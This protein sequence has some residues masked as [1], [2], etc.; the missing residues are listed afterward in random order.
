MTA[1]VFEVAK[2]E[3][4]K[5][6]VD[7]IDFLPIMS[8]ELATALQDIDYYHS[9]I[10]IE[11]LPFESTP[12]R[13]FV[14]QPKSLNDAQ[15][16]QGLPPGFDNVPDNI[17]DAVFAGEVLEHF[18][19][20]PVDLLRRL[21]RAIKPTGSI[22][23]TTPSGTSPAWLNSNTNYRGL[24]QYATFR[25][26]PQPGTEAEVKD[27]HIHLYTA[28]EIHELAA[29]A[30]LH[31]RQMLVGKQLVFELVICQPARSWQSV[32]TA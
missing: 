23:I 12:Q 21:G 4:F 14:V 27:Q 31:V 2:Q 1:F 22:V 11:P 10:Q 8:K 17:Y 5:A 32:I 6:H 26:M 28:Q 9:N 30:G 3:G 20:S 16:N 24:P 13:R 15:V 25:D 7:A 29:E 19:F 18:V